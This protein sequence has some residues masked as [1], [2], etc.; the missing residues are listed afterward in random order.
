MISDCTLLDAKKTRYLGKLE[1][2]TG[3]VKLQGRWFEPFLVRFPLV[4]VSKGSMSDEMIRE[5]MAE[6]YKDNLSDLEEMSTFKSQKKEGEVFRDF[7]SREKKGKTEA[8]NLPE[9]AESLPQGEILIL[10]DIVKHR[11]SS[12]SERYQRLGLNAY[13]GNKIRVALVDKGLIEI[14]DLPI[15]TG[16]VKIFEL[17]DKGKEMLSNMEIEVDISHRKGGLEHEYW[18]SRVAEHFRRKGYR[19]VE[20]YPVGEGKAVDLVAMKDKEMVAIEIETGKSDAIY[21]IQKDLK[22]GFG[23]IYCFVLDEKV[24]QKIEGM[25]SNLELDNTFVKIME[26]NKLLDNPSLSNK[27]QIKPP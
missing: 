11:F 10:K 16:R 20:E 17:T 12:T 19:V 5:R 25:L 2:G 13:Q 22:I 3:M 15:R 27:F 14:R 18:K 26:I 24:K 8:K 6:F 4:R 1:I 7:R 9:K 21:N 23:T